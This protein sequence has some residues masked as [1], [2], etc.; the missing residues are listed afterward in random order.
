MKNFLRLAIAIFFF[1]IIAAA[2]TERDKQEL[3]R[4]ENATVT[5]TEN[6]DFA[7]LNRLIADDFVNTTSKGVVRNKAQTIASWTN[8]APKNAA[9]EQTTVSVVT[10]LND[11]QVRV[12]GKM[13]V[14][15]G[16]D[17]AVFTNK[18][19]SETKSEA[20][21]TDVWEKRK[22][23]W[24]MIANHVSRI[25]S[26]NES[27]APDAQANLEQEFKH[28]LQE[29]ATAEARFDDNDFTHRSSDEYF[30][31]DEKGAVNTKANWLK[32]PIPAEA[33]KKVAEEFAE[34][35]LTEKVEDVRVALYGDTAVVNSRWL[36]NL[37]INEEP[38]FKQFRCT[39]VFVRRDNRWLLVAKH[40]TAIPLDPIPAK[41]NYKIYDDYVGQ[42]QLNSKHI[43]TVTRDGDKLI[44]GKTK[45]YELV[46][47]NDNT[48]V[49]KGDQY[50]IIF[51]RDAQGKVTH[52]RWREFPGVEYNAIKIK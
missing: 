52:L 36:M 2:Q 27:P 30:S 31:T 32:N 43:Y 21:F 12:R 19:A 17:R 33:R 34:V 13:A 7:M 45:K 6:R 3:I 51:V 28:I 22:G 26:S 11:L 35:K 16:L 20:R 29:E 15:T 9:G 1:S 48:F 38:V 24:Q 46:P 4:L 8:N 44:L 37:I 14:V 25:P 41:I 49:Q 39:H 18:D 50:R 42:Y 40:E 10:T 23:A 47:E 5:A